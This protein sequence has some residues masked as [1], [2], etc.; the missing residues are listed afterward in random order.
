MFKVTIGEVGKFFLFIRHGMLIDFFERRFRLPTAARY[1]IFIRHA[2]RMQDRSLIMTQIM[3][4]EMRNAKPP[5][6]F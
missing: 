3:E 4:T 1:D 6:F 2:K 5:E